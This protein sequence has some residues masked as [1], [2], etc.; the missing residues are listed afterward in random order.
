MWFNYMTTS[1]CHHNIFYLLTHMFIPLF[2]PRCGKLT[3]LLTTLMML[4]QNLTYI[5]QGCEFEDALSKAQF[6]LIAIMEMLLQAGADPNEGHAEDP[7][8]SGFNQQS[9]PAHSFGFNSLC[10]AL[11]L[12][13]EANSFTECTA[14]IAAKQC[15]K[16]SWQSHS[17]EYDSNASNMLI[18][19][20]CEDGNNKKQGTCSTPPVCLRTYTG[21]VLLLGYWGARLPCDTVPEVLMSRFPHSQDLITEIS[22]FS[23]LKTVT[24][25]SDNIA[26][27]Q[28]PSIPVMHKPKSLLELS[29]KSI[30][31]QVARCNKLSCLELMPLPRKLKDYCMFLILS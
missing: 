11:D 7:R 25:D 1:I 6:Q 3:P 30:R 31:L 23:S 10:C 15:D 16:S 27:S 17:S 8:N 24:L 9:Q 12:A 28:S 26:E 29:R 21:L 19:E 13:N 5:S 22:K 20:K 4:R 14:N 18:G 2:L